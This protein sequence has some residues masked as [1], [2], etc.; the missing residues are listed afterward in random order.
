MFEL[1]GGQTVLAGAIPGQNVLAKMIAQIRRC[2]EP[3]PL[4][5]DFAKVEVATSSFLLA[6]VFGIRNHC[7]N[8]DMNLYPVIANAND[9]VIEE[10]QR[11]LKDHGEAIATC[12]LSDQHT[13]SAA[14]VVG[15]LEAKQEITLEAVK[16]LKHVDASTLMERY[17]A[18][19]KIGV[20]GWH[21]RLAALVEKCLLMET[22]KGRAKYYQTVLELQ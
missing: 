20:T 16:A 19:E 15:V 6:S 13:V 11:L 12:Q 1:S 8:A 18:T 2:G 17:K 3:T 10:L 7:R 22:K 5:L 14:R 9:M 4:F 21:N